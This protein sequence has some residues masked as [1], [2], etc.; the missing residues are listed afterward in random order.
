MFISTHI[1]AVLCRLDSRE[2]RHIFTLALSQWHTEFVCWLHCLEA[3][4]S[5]LLSGSGAVWARCASSSFEKCLVKCEILKFYVRVNILRK[6]RNVILVECRDIRFCVCCVCVCV[7]Y[8][9]WLYYT[10]RREIQRMFSNNDNF[11]LRFTYFDKNMHDLCQNHPFFYLELI[12]SQMIRKVI[13][14]ESY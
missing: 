11:A 9:G 12:D 3:N 2:F 13:K 4:L 1:V 14:L 7:D 5:L 6:V 8:F 10:Y